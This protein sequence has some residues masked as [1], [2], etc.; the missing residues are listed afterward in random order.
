[1]TVSHYPAEQRTSRLSAGDGLARQFRFDHVP[2]AKP[3]RLFVWWRLV[4][5]SLSAGETD[6]RRQILAHA[7]AIQTLFQMRIESELIALADAPINQI[8]DKFLTSLAVHC[9]PPS[10]CLI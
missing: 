9:L 1:P 3:K 6:D 5:A 7:I 8:V 10:F 2:D 4:L